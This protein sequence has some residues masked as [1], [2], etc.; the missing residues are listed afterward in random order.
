MER[1]RNLTLYHKFAATMIFLGLIPML[2]L[3]IFISNKMIQDYKDALEMQYEQAAFYVGS[4]IETMLN[5]YDTISQMP[6]N[7]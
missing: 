7:Y 6:Y 5:T 2:I 1:V 4:S 3:S